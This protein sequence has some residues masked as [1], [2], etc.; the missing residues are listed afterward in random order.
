VAPSFAASTVAS[1][2]YW[3]ESDGHTS[4]RWRVKVQLEP[5]YTREFIHEGVPLDVLNVDGRTFG[6]LMKRRSHMSL[7][8][9][10][11]Q[12]GLDALRR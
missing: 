10:E 3:F 7:T 9:D 8:D 5:Q 12:A 2:A 1:Y 11:W 4:W 6:N